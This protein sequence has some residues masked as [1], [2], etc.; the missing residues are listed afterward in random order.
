MNVGVNDLL[1]S[2]MASLFSVK[3]PPQLL[4]LR[5]LRYLRKTKSPQTRGSG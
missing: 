3:K 5:R 1:D 2:Q 4:R